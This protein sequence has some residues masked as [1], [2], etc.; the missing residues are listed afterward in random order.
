M[1]S[2]RSFCPFKVSPTRS[3]ESALIATLYAFSSGLESLR[4]D[5]VGGTTKAG[6]LGLCSRVNSVLLVDAG[7]LGVPGVGGDTAGGAARTGTD[8]TGT[9]AD[10]T[11]VNLARAGAGAGVGLGSMDL[12]AGFGNGDGLRSM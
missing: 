11:S 9:G 10:G 2:R 7:V 12:A 5:G 6:G 1:I 8:G 4:L 3:A